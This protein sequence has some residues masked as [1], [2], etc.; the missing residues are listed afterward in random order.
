MRTNVL[1]A[2]VAAAAA[3]SYAVWRLWRRNRAST[4]SLL[5]PSA[6]E[7]QLARD[8]LL[9]AKAFRDPSWTLKYCTRDMDLAE[10][11]RKLGV[12]VLAMHSTL[13]QPPSYTL[14]TMA[15]GSE[16]ATPALLAL[17]WYRVNGMPLPDDLALR[18]LLPVYPDRG[19]V[20]GRPFVD[21]MCLNVCPQAMICVREAFT[22]HIMGTRATVLLAYK[23]TAIALGAHM[24]G[25]LNMPLVVLGEEPDTTTATPAVTQE[26]RHDVTVTAGFRRGAVLTMNAYHLC[27]QDRVVIV[28]NVV[29]SGETMTSLVALVNGAGASVVACLAIYSFLDAADAAKL[30]N[31]FSIVHPA[32]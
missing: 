7:Q 9:A 4:K 25:A 13:Q 11:L 27:G 21:T 32:V 20:E 28:D 8:D 26:G 5:L 19:T 18:E 2:A 3:G 17:T 15:P 24:S 1:A 10:R 22:R 6:R 23:A 12:S 29:S 14:V 31:F 30:P 16:N